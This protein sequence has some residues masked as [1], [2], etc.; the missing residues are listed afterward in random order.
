MAN[1]VTILSVNCRG[2][3]DTK[4]RNDVFHYL[5]GKK[6]SIYCLQETHF[7]E[8]MHSIITSKWGY[9][10]FFNSSSSNKKGLAI[11]INNNFEFTFVKLIVDDKG[12]YMILQL[13]MNDQTITLINLHSPNNDDPA[14]YDRVRGAIKSIRNQELIVAGD[15]NLVLNPE[16]DSQNYKHT[17]NP[18]CREKVI[19][20][21]NELSLVDIWRELN[22]QCK[23]FTWRRSQ[24]VLQQSR[25]DFFLINENL[26][27]DVISADIESGYRTDHS[28]VTITFRFT[29]R[30]R[31]RTF[32][33]F[34]S[35]LLKDKEYV[36]RMKETIKK[37]KQTYAKNADSVDI[38]HDDNLEF[39]IDDQL[40]FEVMLMDIR[41][42]TISYATFKKRIE[43]SREELLIKEI[44]LLEQNFNRKN[45]DDLKTKQIEL[46]ELRRKRM[47]GVLTRSR[48]R[49]VGEGEKVSKY[50][51]NLEKRHYTSKIIRK[52][53]KK[54]G[55]F[56]TEQDDIVKETK[57]FYESLYMQE[58]QINDVNLEDL[59]QEHEENIPKLTEKQRNDLEGLISKEEVLSTLKRMKNG[60]SPGS[61]GFTVEFYKFFWNDL[62]SFLV[63]AINESFKK[64]SLSSP[65][66][67]GIITLL[68]KG[69]K[70]RQFLKNWRPITLLNVSYKIASGCIA[71]RIKRILPDIIHSDQTGFV[72]G[73]CISENTRL[74]YDVIHYTEKRNVSGLLLLIDFE[75]AFDSVSWSFIKKTL[76]FLKFG[77]D[78]KKW[79]DIFYKNTKSCVI[80][81]G[82][83]S[84]WFSI[85]RGCR[86]GDPLSPYIFFYCVQKS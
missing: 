3:A 29:E 73:R 85:E 33:K 13:K 61:D 51:C 69:D 65:Q 5:K 54:D 46:E 76:I 37:T 47:E 12:D 43:Q 25:L 32:W 14:F 16:L 49:W 72:S 68:P 64:E 45:E 21:T 55:T 26:V 66:K 86:Q 10:A 81:N 1:D 84:T 62:G 75:K 58:D 82:Q 60:T 34:N 83:V 15:W 52:I 56:V 18:K 67:E 53:E 39:Q 20:L 31:G 80:V 59:I 28:A 44:E 30:A 24:P 48:A 70:P 74:L 36:R 40:L 22:A 63:R 35:S 23:R 38:I 41:S 6:Y 19:D 11:L 57:S 2:L 4:K 71:N 79:I 78:I 7:T 8:E 50:F 42:A 17:N 77:P 27:A 9:K